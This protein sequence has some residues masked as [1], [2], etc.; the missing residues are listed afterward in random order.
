MK[1]AKY[2]PVEEWKNVVWKIYKVIEFAESID[3]NVGGPIYITVLKENN[4]IEMLSE[5]DIE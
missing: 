5:E 2:Q 1:V 4:E 3:P